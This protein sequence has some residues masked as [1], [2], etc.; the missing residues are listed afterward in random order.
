[1][2]VEA[3]D[4]L[5]AFHTNPGAAGEAC[6]GKRVRVNGV[7]A[8]VE[9]PFLR[10]SYVFLGDPSK[11]KGLVVCTFTSFTMPKGLIVGSRASVE[12]LC[13]HWFATDDKVV[14][15]KCSVPRSP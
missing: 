12:G 8:H 7:V 5:E 14:L 11:D 2:T 9:P 1:M 3:T 4:L 6:L 10:T 13:E 15:D